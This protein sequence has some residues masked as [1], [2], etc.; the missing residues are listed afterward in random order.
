MGAFS[1]LSGRSAEIRCSDDFVTSMLSRVA[2]IWLSFTEY[3]EM[4]P[5]LQSYNEKIE[6][7]TFV[8]RVIVFVACGQS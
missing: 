2:T 7:K 5:T 1:I 6:K 8:A 4:G 3:I